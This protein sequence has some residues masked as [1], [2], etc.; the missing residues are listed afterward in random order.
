MHQIAIDGP[1]GSG[2]STLA[3]KLAH[4]LGYLYLDTGALYRTVGYYARIH[5]ID[6][7]DETTLAAHF[8][9]IDLD[10][11]WIEG[12]Q[13]VFLNGEDVSGFI[14]TP[15]MSMY[16]SAVSALPAVRAFLLDK[17][18]VFAHTHNVVMD[19]RDIG[20]V[21][22]PDADVKLFLH[23]DDRVRAERR[24]L[25]LI[26]KGQSVTLSEVLEDMRRRDEAD[27]ARTH[28]PCVPAPDAVLFDNTRLGIDETVEKALEIINEK[29]AAKA[30]RA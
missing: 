14:R 23:A 20:T 26:E 21:V 8:D 22:L 16:A 9:D 29:L 2:K 25:E 1:S 6:P 13:H 5:D 7:H 18:R 24:Y 4:K 12:S 17:Q 10:I 30:G 27:A 3:K 15:E 19:G 28:A 11:V